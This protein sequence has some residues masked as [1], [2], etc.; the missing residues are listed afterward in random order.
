MVL[1]ASFIYM[2][3]ALPALALLASSQDVD[4]F[5][6]SDRCEVWRTHIQCALSRQI[7]LKKLIKKKSVNEEYEIY[8]NVSKSILDNEVHSRYYFINFFMCVLP[9][10]STP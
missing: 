3:R 1:M 8:T 4:S 6:Q 10:S 9:Y 5:S 2:I 7:D